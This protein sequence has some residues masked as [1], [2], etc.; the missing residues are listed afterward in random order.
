MSS[1]LVDEP[2]PDVLT[3][4]D[5][6]LIRQVSPIHKKTDDTISV[7]SFA[8]SKRDEGML[9]TL[10]GSVGADEAYR[11]WTEEVGSNSLGSFGVTVG[12]ID[13]VEVDVP[14]NGPQGLQALDD[15]HMVHV[16]DHV[17]VDFNALLSRGQRRQAARKLLECALG[18]GGPLNT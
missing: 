7:E 13:S 12:E 3:N 4:P 11:R 9:S 6:L 16:E 5:D 18:R 2:G 8:P 15:A 17:S 1:D 10:H 14:G